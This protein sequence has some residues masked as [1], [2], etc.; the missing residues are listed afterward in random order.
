M[1]F[2]SKAREIIG[3]ENG[4]WINSEPLSLEKLRGKIV[5]LDFWA[6]SCINCVRTLPVLK[7]MWEKFKNKNVMI[8]GIHTP[9]FEFEKDTENVM[10]A[11]EKYGIKYPI[12]S[13][14]EGVNWIN[15]GNQYWPRAAL[16]DSKGN[17]AME[18][19]GEAGYE[20]LASKIAELAGIS[21]TVSEQRR[22]YSLNMSRETYCGSAR[23][24][25][26]GS[27]IKSGKN[28][29]IEFSDESKHGKGI[30]YLSGSWKQESEFL[31]SCGDGYITYKF[32]AG[33]V[34]LVMDAKGKSE[35]EILL[36]EKPL[37]KDFFG[38]DVSLKENK[39]VL[40]V[41]K[42]DMYN[43]FNSK[44]YAEAEIKIFA[45]KGLRVYA[46]TFG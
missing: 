35:L 36:N 37:P 41:E 34:N 14:P 26:I 39:S 27:K 5:L 17:I 18:H 10:H 22:T 20:R 4:A 2:E 33:E 32:F 1:V 12:A 25:G 11:V 16:I 21:E 31:E 30:I 8:I 46:Y 7:E 23:N 28:D 24:N 13:D 15:Y 38:K 43:L 40:A 3:I 19:V 45:K 44:D 29:C 42:P 9:E 6:Y